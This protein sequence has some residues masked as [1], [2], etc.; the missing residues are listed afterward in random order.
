ML[1]NKLE[2][3]EREVHPGKALHLTMVTADG[4]ARNAHADIVQ[5]ELTLDELF[6]N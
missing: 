1:L 2:A 6:E 4:L 3:F 5:R